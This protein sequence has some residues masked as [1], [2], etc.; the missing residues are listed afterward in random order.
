M[1]II[2][3]KNRAATWEEWVYPITDQLVTNF[4][5]LERFHG[6]FVGIYFYGIKIGIPNAS[7]YPAGG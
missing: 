4:L 3:K 6:N 1:G 5:H 7:A 2:V